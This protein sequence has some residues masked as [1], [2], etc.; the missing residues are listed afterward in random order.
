MTQLL[1]KCLNGVDADGDGTVKPAMMEGGLNTV[2]Q[3]AQ[4]GG[5]LAP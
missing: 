4:L 3:H 5:F 1:E 2:F